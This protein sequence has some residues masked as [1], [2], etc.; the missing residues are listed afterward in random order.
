MRISHVSYFQILPVLCAGMTAIAAEYHVAT[1]GRDANNGSSSAPFLTLS[2]A[3]S[4]AQPGDTITV[5]TGVYRERVTPP[6]GGDSDSKRIVYQAAPG[7]RVEI[8]G[9][10]VVKGW[11]RVRDNVWKVTLPNSFFGAFNPYSDLIHGDWFSAN[12]RPHHTGAV[13]LNG[14]WLTEATNLDELFLPEGT[15]P[16]WMSP[17]NK[18]TLLNVA[19]FRI[20]NN[21][22]STNIP[23]SSFAA[24]QGV[25]TA[26]CTQG[27]DC[28]GWIDQGDW[29]RYDG[30]DFGIGSQEVEL[31][32]ASASSGGVIEL[33]LDSPTGELLGSCA[34][35][36]TGDWQAWVLRKTGIKPTSGLHTLCLTFKTLPSAPSSA[37]ALNPRLWFAT[38]DN[39]NT[40]LWAQFKG[41]NPNN[42]T[43]EINARQT[44]FTPGKTN[45][46]YIT[47]RGF[48]LAHA[49]TPWAPPTAAQIG[50]VSAYWCKGWIIESNEI[51]YSTCSGVALGKYGDE[52][53]NRAESAEG[54]VGTLTRALTNGWNKASVG[55]HIV[56]NNHIHHCEQ[57]GIVGSLG[58]AYSTVTGNEIHDIHVRQLFGGAEMAGIKFHGAIDVEISHNHIY[59]CGDCAGLWLDWMAQ[60]TRVSANLFHDNTGN[61]G[62]IFLE[63][64]HGPILLDNNL[65]L[66][67][68]KALEL[69]CQGIAFVHNLILGPIQNLRGDNRS[70]P[71]QPAHGTGVAGLFDAA[72]GDCGDHRFYNNLFAGR[73]NL[74]SIDNPAFSCF[75][76]GNVYAKGSQ[77]PTLDTH[78]LAK[79]DFDPVVKLESKEDG[80]YLVVAGDKSW[81]DEAGCQPVTSERLSKAK[82]SQCAFENRDGSPLRVSTDYFGGQR[83]EAR[84][85]P[86]PFETPG[87]GI[88]PIK[89]WPV[90]RQ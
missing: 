16:G 18:E 25:K 57:T 44:V 67:R 9:S 46:N 3:A 35:E 17:A 4:I 53:D 73:Y 12:N 79:S 13:Y 81:R 1:T 47:V 52:W 59:R 77:L 82:V 45:V 64:Q 32:V 50:I 74:R 89:V 62:D 11:E 6:R 7:E 61:C 34:V 36:N 86:G 19:W 51:S 5:H 83:D 42:E 65:I 54:Y 87:D 71:F 58:V 30:V 38:V 33:R 84:P 63:M 41:I 55:S 48:K 80:W 22:A 24:Q 43:V 75:A 2:A 26:P 21:P 85:F 8:K 70:T 29:M 23:A 27:G 49:A 40:T 14:D 72:K 90:A 28:V 68:Q 37:P 69:N 76:A 60:G 88:Q 56:R 31:S 39:A 20:V 78:S 15:T 66:S 10:E